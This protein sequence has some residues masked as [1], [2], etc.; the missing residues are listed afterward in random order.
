[1]LNDLYN[2]FPPYSEA[3]RRQNR[4]VTNTNFL[5]GPKAMADARR[6]VNQAL[7]GAPQFFTVDVD[8]GP[9][10]KRAEWSTIITNEINKV[11]KHSRKYQHCL[12]AT[13]AGVVLHGI[14]PVLWENKYNWCPYEVGIED[15]LV[16]S[17]TYVSMR[18]LPFIA[19]YRQ[20][21]GFELQKCIS[22]PK[23]DRAWN[24]PLAK[25]LIDWV[26]QQAKSLMSSSWP[27]VWS[28]EKQAERIKQD[29]GLYAS[30]ALPTIDTFDLY[31]W[32]DDGKSAGWNRRIILDAWGS[33]GVGGAGGLTN[34][35]NS[36]KVPEKSLYG[37][38]NEFLFNPGDRVYGDSLDQIGH[39]QF[40]D[41]SA[42]PPFRYHSVRSLGFLL[43]SVCH[44]QNRMRCR[45]NDAV[46]EAM[47][48]Y[49]RVASPQDAERLTKVDLI[50]KGIIPEGLNFVGQND[51]WQVPEALVERNMAMN[52]QTMTDNSASFVQDT[53]H[54]RDRDETATRTMAKVNASAALVGAMLN[55]MYIQQTFQHREIARRFCI[56]NSPDP[57]VNRFRTSVLKKGVPKEMLSVERW[58]I[59][60]ARVVGSGNKML[61]VAM[62]DKLMALRPTLGPDAQKIVER[63]FVLANSDDPS[64]SETLI[65]AS[66]QVSKGQHDA[67]ALL[68]TLMQGLP[69]SVQDGMNHQDYI[70]TW[71]HGMATVIK[72][73]QMT[74]NVPTPQEL[75]GLQNTGLHVSQHIQLMA[76]DKTAQ[77]QVRKYGDEL[78]ELMNLVKAFGQ[79]LQ[80]QMQK[81]SGAQ[82]GEKSQEIAAK[83]QAIMLQAQTKSKIAE[84]SHALKT[85]QR[86]LQFE[87]QLKQNA[88]KHQ[89][90][91]AARELEAESN[92][93]MNRM[94]STKE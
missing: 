8:Y 19:F 77:Q 18:N 1:M 38:R 64:L 58:N 55:K 70:E 10:W 92:I 40:A 48:Q 67:Q 52:R 41:C 13:A 72:R 4:F 62:A 37:T 56:A 73:I 39:F 57:E 43:Y 51:R 53:D 17:N 87:Q 84:E 90:D 5:E 74:G 54:Q 68:G 81:Q 34:I 36:K 31:F 35:S 7:T 27:E 44:L 12:D 6:Q 2:G 30:D 21:T 24:I 80:E 28:P 93:R 49:F 9:V 14:A 59:Q 23:V 89:V 85:A 15:V 33:P 26:D 91:I 75:T 71:L 69:V 78:K 22:G 20:Y 79:R 82:N 46:F 88:Q 47:L 45:F 25:H 50:D 65:P 32:N 83:M 94:K 60:P 16:P 29:G 11:M 63:L 76:Q 3:E 61:Q 86:K 42:V 66:P